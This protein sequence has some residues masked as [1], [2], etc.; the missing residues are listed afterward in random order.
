MIL[1]GNL[2]RTLTGGL[3]VVLLQATNT[4]ALTGTCS[5]ISTGPVPY[6]AVTST[7][8]IVI[9]PTANPP[10]LIDRLGALVPGFATP[11]PVPVPGPGQL[12]YGH[13]TRTEIPS[14]GGSAGGFVSDYNSLAVVNFTTNTLT[15]NMV[16]VRWGFARPAVLGQATYNVPITVSAGPIPGSFI[17][18]GSLPAQSV[19]NVGT[20]PAQSLTSIVVPVNGGQTLLVQGT[21][22]PFSG[23]CQF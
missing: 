5:M 23:V 6:G 13:V 12:T 19:P 2:L 21:G 14:L 10:T 9:T 8:S 16:F 17:V 18:A 3:L 20:V 11:T 22:H 1:R 7:E 15:L 4:Y